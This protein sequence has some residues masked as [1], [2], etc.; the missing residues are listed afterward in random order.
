MM[1]TE[2]N[3]REAIPVEIAGITLYC[4]E[5]RASAVKSISEE[6]TVSGR[7][8]VTE[9]YPRGTKLTFSGRIYSETNPLSCIMTINNSL[10]AKMTYDIIY[11]GLGFINCMV[12]GYTAEDCGEDFI[13][14][15]VTVVTTNNV[16]PLPENF[17]EVLGDG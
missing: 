17:G 16:I 14:T 2:F 1:T 10:H 7:N 12:Q 6:P 4:E 9:S 8:A 5:F 11:R 3:R 13:K 15:S